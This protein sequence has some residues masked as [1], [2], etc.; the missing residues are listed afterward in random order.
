MDPENFDVTTNQDLAQ[1]DP[2]TEQAPVAQEPEIPQPPV[3]AAESFGN[4]VE[5]VSSDAGKAA[6]PS[7]LPHDLGIE[8]TYKSDFSRV[9]G[10]HEPRVMA[11]LLRKDRFEKEAK[12]IRSA[13]SAK[14]IFYIVAASVLFV[15]I[16]VIFSLLFRGEEQIKYIENKRVAALIPSDLDTGI[17]LTHLDASKLKQALFKVT[18]K[19]QEEDSLNQIYYFKEQG[20]SVVQRLSVQ[21]VFAASQSNVPELFL[22]N[23]A[24]EFMHGVYTT[25]EPHPFL[26]FSIDSYDRSLHA[27]Y[28]WEGSM[29]DDLAP[30]LNIPAEALDRS[31]VEDGFS[32]DVIKNK[33]VRVARYVPREKDRRK[34]LLN[35]L[36][37]DN[38]GEEDDLSLGEEVSAWFGRHLAL[39][40]YAQLNIGNQNGDKAIDDEEINLVTT[41]S[42]FINTLATEF[43]C[44]D[45]MTGDRIPTTDTSYATRCRVGNTQVYLFKPYRCNQIECKEGN[46]VVSYERFGEPGVVCS[47]TSRELEYTDTLP[48]RCHEFNDLLNLESIEGINLC[49]DTKGKFLPGVTTPTP[50]IRCTS[51]LNRDDNMCLTP[52]GDLIV[53]R[54]PAPNPAGSICFSRFDTG[55]TIQQ[56]DIQENLPVE[57]Y[58]TMY[59]QFRTLNGDL[60]RQAAAI[61]YEIQAIIGLA[62]FFNLSDDVIADLKEVSDFFAAVARA[63]ILE[64][65]AIRRGAEIVQKLEAILNVL[66]PQGTWS[67]SR[68]DGSGNFFTRVRNLIE[69]VKR[70]LGLSHNVTWITLNGKLPQGKIIYAGQSVEG[71]APLQQAMNLLLVNQLQVS[72]TLDGQTQDAISGIQ[73]VNGLTVTGVADLEFLNLMNAIVSGKGSLFGGLN[74]ATIDEAFDPRYLGLGAYNQQTQSLQILLYARGYDILTID[75]VFDQQTCRA[76]QQFQ[77]ANNLILA[78]DG[79]C[80]LSDE[81]ITTLNDILIEGNYIGSGFELGENNILRG[82]GVLSDVYGPG[83]NPFDDLI[84]EAEARASGIREGDVVLMY[85]FLDERTLL[86]TSHESV[87][88]EVIER[89]AFADIFE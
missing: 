23:V 44:F 71:V 2:Q 15:A 69:L 53:D 62:Y 35:L 37:S 79:S 47:E 6:P 52:N 55:A 24:P 25:D 74:L 89:R 61:S 20:A 85:T 78:D 40:A 64:V 5:P 34:R 88:T 33:N 19:K 84:T 18:Q 9:I 77:A 49:F 11:E 45:I 1:S 46:K 28:E 3:E 73:F 38:A 43:V 30:Y 29:I 4:R 16:I 80:S 76:L 42:S 82:T 10:S 51:P 48:K 83:Q 39:P 60:R 59:E 65:D 14:N 50:D 26:L 7:D 41:N 31:L 58:N 12:T 56:T 54:L 32:D 21:E 22:E 72:G 63:D 70:V 27:L 87:I 67:Y 75:G 13:K 17:N 36:K 8:Q 68:P 57:T 86:I 66:D 81:T